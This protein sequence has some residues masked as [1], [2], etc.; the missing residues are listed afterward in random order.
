LI[1]PLLLVH[2]SFALDLQSIAVRYKKFHFDVQGD[3]LVYRMTF[4][5]FFYWLCAF[6]AGLF[7]GGCALA[8]FVLALFDG[9]LLGSAGSAAILGLFWGGVAGY[10][11]LSEMQ[12]MF[13]FGNQRLEKKGLF[14]AGLNTYAFS[15]VEAVRIKFD[16]ADE[17]GFMVGL[18]MFGGKSFSFEYR[19][20][21]TDPQ[22]SDMLLLAVC[23]AKRTN[24]PL[25][26]DGK[27]LQSHQKFQD[28]YRRLKAL[29]KSGNGGE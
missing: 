14:G 28:I 4:K 27:A 18:D 2:P 10:M 17:Q 29:E 6:F 5:G 13:D 16:N 19:S 24:A 26:F 9:E 3:T 22:S 23:L 15:E 7:F 12:C 8:G 11:L 20:Q 21:L 1:S 25:A